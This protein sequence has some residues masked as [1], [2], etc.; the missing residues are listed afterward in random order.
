MYKK[1]IALAIHVKDK[2]GK[3]CDKSCPGLD[4]TLRGKMI[5]TVG[6]TGT[7]HKSADLCRCGYH[8]N[9][10][11][12]VQEYN[13]TG[14]AMKIERGYW[15]VDCQHGHEEDIRNA[16]LIGRGDVVQE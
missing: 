6:V 4:V 3:Y 14:K 7:S 9:T 2:D 11:L 1:R 8:H 16:R 10:E 12:D 5:V 15:C 13:K